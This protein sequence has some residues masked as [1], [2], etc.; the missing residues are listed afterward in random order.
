MSI[1]SLEALYTQKL[2][3]YAAN[4][5]RMGHLSQPDA[6]ATCF[7]K[8][9]G[10][11][12]S[13]EIQVKNGCISDYAHTVEACA[14]GKTSASIVAHNIIGQSLKDVLHLRDVMHVFLTQKGDAP[15]G[16]WS[17]L[18]LLAPIQAFPQ[19]HASTLLV[20]EALA[21]AIKSL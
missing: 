11:Q 20:F 1:P 21:K 18:A 7:A 19:R 4:I 9:C 13:V 5:P 8:L 3:D 12:I 17:E 6:S 16:V 15:T 10:S 2:L 14:L